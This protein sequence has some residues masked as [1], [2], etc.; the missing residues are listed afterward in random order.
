MRS[1]LRGEVGSPGQEL[2]G[3]CTGF[4]TGHG[5]REEGATR[6]AR[7]VGRA[8]TSRCHQ[9]GSSIGHPVRTGPDLGQGPSGSFSVPRICCHVEIRPG[10]RGPGGSFSADPA[11]GP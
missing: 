6:R 5:A 4:G 9:Q 11:L 10:L 7:G 1:L 3:E 2:E 8:L